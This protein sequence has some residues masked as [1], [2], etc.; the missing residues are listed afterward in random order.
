[1]AVS[2]VKQSTDSITLQVTIP[3][4]RSMLDSESTIESILNE[5]GKIAT[6]ELLKKFDTD[7]S[8]IA[9]GSVKMT[10]MGLVSKCYQTPYG[11]IEIERHVYQ[12][13]KG[14]TTFCPLE[15]D[16]RIILTSTPKF[17]AQISHKMAE[18]A[19]AQV[20][21]DLSVNHGRQVSLALIQRLSEAVFSVVQ[22]KEESWSYHVPEIKD[23]TIKTVGI[24]LDGTC[25]LM[26]E[27]GYRQAVVGTIALYDNDGERQ[28]TTYIAAA[29]EYGKGQFK[30][31]LAREI[32]RTKKLYPNAL[33]IGI[34]DGSHDNWDF[35]EQHTTRQ[36]LDFYH[37]T[38]YLTKV[39]ESV[40]STSE[41]KKNW[42]NDRC[43]QLK[44]TPEAAKDILDEMINFKNNDLTDKQREGVDAAVTYFKNNIDKS[45]MN[46]AES[47]ANKYVIGSG[48]TEAACK[49]IVKQRL[50]KSGMK[51]KEKGAAIILSL[52]TLSRSTGRW[53]QFWRKVNQYGFPIAA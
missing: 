18:M 50:C 11:E 48:V 46:Y 45:R 38:E 52:R 5:T 28:H 10:S 23:T 36:T 13:S 39:S 41:E 42:L 16:A 35:L 14:G 3:F 25:M 49:T 2:L 17:A 44:N 12:T 24:G 31:R 29:P 53:E 19:G 30:E 15:R 47:V 43:H 6:N 34:A 8:D 7:G 51:W 40:F 4:N 21:D 37:A 22:I 26:C 1:M 32:E 20:R 33:Y 9:M 27:G